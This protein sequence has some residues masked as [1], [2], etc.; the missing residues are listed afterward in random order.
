MKKP[1]C[2]RRHPLKTCLLRIQMSLNKY[3]QDVNDAGS[4][5]DLEAVKRI[6]NEVKV[7]FL[8]WE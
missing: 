7:S 2:L 1:R 5:G 6:V 8:D 3:I 4:R